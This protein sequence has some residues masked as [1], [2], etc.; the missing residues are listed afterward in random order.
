M[1]VRW[2]FAYFF[3]LMDKDYEFL[4]RYVP[5]TTEDLI[6]DCLSNVEKGRESI[7]KLHR[8]VILSQTISSNLSVKASKLDFNDLFPDKKT[9][10]KFLL[11]PNEVVPPKVSPQ[12]LQQASHIYL[13]MHQNPIDLADVIL[14]ISHT[15]DFNTL[16]WSSLPSLY[17]FFSSQ[18]H[19]QY[20]VPFYTHI[21]NVAK[22]EIAMHMLLPVFHN[23][24][25]FRFIESSLTSF[26]DFLYT[27]EF[28][29][30]KNGTESESSIGLCSKMLINCFAKCSTQL[31]HCHSLLFRIMMKKWG[32]SITSHFLFCSIIRPLTIQ[33]FE[34]EGY[35]G[36]LSVLNKILDFI[37][38]DHNSCS[39]LAIALTSTSPFLDLPEEY[40]CFGHQYLT[41]Y[42]SCVDILTLIRTLTKYRTVPSSLI[43]PIIETSPKEAMFW[44]R[45]FPKCKLPKTPILR[46]LV[47][48][49]H[50]F[51]FESSIELDRIWRRIEII[52]EDHLEDPNHYLKSYAPKF[53][54]RTRCQE[55][56]EY[57]ELKMKAK[58]T[59]LSLMFE[60][61]MEY[62]Y[63][64]NE[65]K[66][67]S[68]I[69]RSHEY[70]RI[71]LI[72]KQ[73]AMKAHSRGYMN[74]NYAHELSSKLFDSKR[75][76]QVMFLI[77]IELYLP[78][79]L[80]GMENDMV[81]LDN[82]WTNQLSS[83]SMKKSPS[84]MVFKNC[85]SSSLYQASI[86]KMKLVDSSSLL[87]SYINLMKSIQFFLQLSKIEKL[88]I[89]NLQRIILYSQ[90][91][92][93][94]R[95]Y[96]IL[97]SIAIR[98]PL[99]LSLCSEEEYFQWVRFESAMLSFFTSKPE[100]N[101]A[102]FSFQEKLGE[103]LRKL[104]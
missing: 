50:P 18:E 31:F 67:W 42:S 38:N 75:I 26:C 36:I 8:V 21:I 56:L 32:N 72:A 70:M 24:C 29:S 78:A 34:S 4:D 96:I 62:S 71:F 69:C 49:Y 66:E 44:F 37:E 48:Q 35:Y 87:F 65:I 16:V 57:G 47:F 63:F 80:S 83:S 54:E 92:T 28:L 58:L 94:I 85:S 55:L 10:P 9:R 3:L 11:K 98:N 22:Q 104:F 103:K 60:K 6:H 43:A 39:T 77:L 101:Q 30:Q 73:T 51:S 64:L 99:Y 5:R 41:F 19:L 88:D 25:I 17:G 91:K 79:F 84:A 93:L 74:I 68:L 46:P 82:I 7:I 33:W 53:I 1:Q 59:S 45:I 40:I 13:F 100:L 97:S 12:L 61:F 76:T 2:N 23:P 90:N 86:S 52:S 81:N 102:L 95:V 89:S 15:P 27:K 14:K 20:A